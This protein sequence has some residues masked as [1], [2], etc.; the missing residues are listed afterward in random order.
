VQL[1]D[2][3]ATGSGDTRIAACVAIANNSDLVDA[4]FVQAL[5]R[6]GLSDTVQHALVVT[7]M[8]ML[9]H[10]DV[11]HESTPMM[12]ACPYYMPVLLRIIAQPRSRYIPQSPLST[13]HTLFV[14]FTFCCSFEAIRS[15]ARIIYGKYGK[16]NA[17][18]L[19]LGLPRILVRVINDDSDTTDNRV[20]AMFCLS[21]MA[22]HA[23]ASVLGDQ[24]TVTCALRIIQQQGTGKAPIPLAPLP[25]FATRLFV[26]APS[27]IELTP[28]SSNPCPPSPSDMKLWATSAKFGFT[29]M[30]KTVVFLHYVSRAAMGAHM[31][32]HKD[33]QSILLPISSLADDERRT[34]N[35]ALMC[36][37]NVMGNLEA[38]KGEDSP[39]MLMRPDV[40]GVG[41]AARACVWHCSHA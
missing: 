39:I 27:S 6:Q 40:V 26:A 18:L 17:Q 34:A 33:A 37:V 21:C 25:F 22:T 20:C 31:L 14:V 28:A 30:N 32:R 35:A 13:H 3:A 29:L 5:R 36:L 10:D 4:A 16:A 1:R 15:I 38:T 23:P 19:P 24:D 8:S 12:L 2:L 11:K 41:K 7:M 9:L